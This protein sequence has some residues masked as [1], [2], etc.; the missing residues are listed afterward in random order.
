MKIKKRLEIN[1]TI[2]EK[3]KIYNNFNNEQLSD[4]LSN[5]I[6]NQ[7]KGSS[8]KTNI[9]INI[10]HNY[11]ISD[12]EKTKIIDAI[13]SNYGIDIKENLLTIKYEH[14]KEIFLLLLGIILLITSK[15]LVDIK[16]PI[17]AEIIS[18]FGCVVIWEI[19][20]NI[21]FVETTKKIENQRLER[22]K[23]AKITFNKTNE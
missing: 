13:R 18:I 1:I 4:E 22:L 12:N 21:F 10:N 5:Y 14:I 6:Y 15:I 16:S 2:N 23:K 11:D 19:A 7:C 3:T 17:L 9:N 8:I 20:Y